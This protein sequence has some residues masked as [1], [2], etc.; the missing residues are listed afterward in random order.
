MADIQIIADGVSGDASRS[1]LR[2][3]MVWIN[4]TVGYFFYFDNDNPDDFNYVKTSDSGQTWA[5]PVVIKSTDPAGFMLSYD[6][7]Y[8]K[9]TNGDTGNLIHI[10]YAVNNPD[11]IQYKSL[12]VTT[13]VLSTESPI[14]AL[15]T[16][17]AS[18]P[19]SISITKTRGGN[20]YAA[21]NLIPNA[22]GDKGFARSIDGGSTWA[23]RAD[24]FAGELEEDQVLLFPGNE[25][26][27]QDVWAAYWD[28]SAQE[29]SLKVYDDSADSWAE[30][31]ISGGFIG[32]SNT[33]Q[34]AGA[35]RHS[36]NHLILVA[37][38]QFF[39]V[40]DM[41]SWD[42]NGAASITPK[43]DVFTATADRAAACMTFDQNTDDIYVAYYEGPGPFSSIQ[44]MYKISTDGGTTWA[45]Q[46]QYSTTGRQ[47]RGLWSTVSV[48]TTGQD[49]RWQPAM[50]ASTSPDEAYTNFGNSIAL[51]G[52]IPPSPNP[53]AEIR[54][55]AP[56]G[57]AGDIIYITPD[58][59]EY[60]LIT[61][62]T[63]GRHVLS[64]QGLGTPPIE[65]VTQR[66]P[67]QD[68]ETVKDFFLRPRTVQILE[69]QNFCDRDAWWNGRSDILN[70][71]RPNR[72]T[73]PDGTTPGTLRFFRTDG[74]ARDLRVFISTGPVF[75]P[76]VSNQWDEWSFQELLRFIAHDP[77]LFST[78]QTVSAFVI[79]LDADLVFPITFPISF[80]A[81]LVDDTLNITYDGTWETFPIITIV[82]PIKTP[83]ID[84]NT[85]G[86]KLEFTIDIAVGQTVTIDLTEGVKTVVDQAGNN[87]IGGLT[88][89]SDLGSFHIAPDPEATNGLNVIRL[90]GSEP[91]GATSVSLSFF[92]RFYGM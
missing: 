74:T 71:I 39:A 63:P 62:H 17:A 86:E 68:G 43:T 32:S 23:D 50:F 60:Q 29:L 90:R 6:T 42:I 36:D 26:D 11:G 34:M 66:G 31:L 92:V 18:S 3:G 14:K 15:G 21:W 16:A 45:A 51:S 56:G 25:L 1:S 24:I 81:G 57:Q 78:T 58:N 49:G 84:N 55:I 53:P 72:Q 10:A 41:K 44:L 33:P 83:R 79:A 13:D 48:A 47:Y 2:G 38:E 12:N 20:L 30:T 46:V 22:S 19:F 9:Y 75:E 76:R 67:F 87:L 59:R 88:T 65:Y 40:Q 8:D 89:N 70:E 7:W 91:T 73:T 52:G 77:I 85:T 64:F 54:A 69:R 80:G 28:I 4:L 27:N 37:H 61:P 5:T 35:I 82:G